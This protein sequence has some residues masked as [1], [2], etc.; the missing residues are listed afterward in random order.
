MRRKT[1][2]T[3]RI[4]APRPEAVIALDAAEFGRY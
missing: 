4:A 2:S 1:P 3:P